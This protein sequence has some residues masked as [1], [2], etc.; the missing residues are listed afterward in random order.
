MRRD[1]AD[2]DHAQLRLGHAQVLAVLNNLVLGCFM[3][4]QSRCTLDAI[5][6]TILMGACPGSLYL[7]NFA[8]ALEISKNYA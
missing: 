1:V 6:P 2:E 5:S 3:Q 4:S 7:L 8:A